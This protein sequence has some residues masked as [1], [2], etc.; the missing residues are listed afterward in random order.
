MK[1]GQEIFDR[2]VCLLGYSDAGGA[3]VCGP[4]INGRALDLLN[5]VLAD[6]WRLEREDD[7][8]PLLSVHDEVPL[9]AAAREEAMPFGVAAYLAQTEG[10]GTNQQ[11][12]AALYAAKRN[13]VERPPRRRADALPVAEEGDA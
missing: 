9:S 11:V 3:A 7:P 12:F 1:T 10:D 4:Q 5:Q 2:A 8:Q 13:R 6:L